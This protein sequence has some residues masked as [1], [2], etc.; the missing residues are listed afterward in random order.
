MSFTETC[1]CCGRG[2]RGAISE[3]PKLWTGCPC[4]GMAKC[5]DCARCYEHCACVSLEERVSRLDREEKRA[6]EL[7]GEAYDLAV[8]LGVSELEGGGLTESRLAEIEKGL[9]VRYMAFVR[10]RRR[11]DAQMALTANK[12]RLE[13]LLAEGATESETEHAS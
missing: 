6:C 5:A 2:G 8:R 7:N 9:R 10:L 11:A 3:F 4:L 1:A 12:A 13:A